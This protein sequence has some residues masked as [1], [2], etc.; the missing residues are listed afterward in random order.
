MGW[1]L[2]LGIATVAGCSGMGATPAPPVGNAE[3]SN[4]FIDDVPVSEEAFDAMMSTLSGDREGWYCAELEWVDEDGNLQGG[5]REGWLATDP[6][7]HLYRVVLRTAGPDSRSE[8]TRVRRH[9][10]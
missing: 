3:P 8:V 9:R 10:R 7:G 2:A 6:K 5:G 4:F 1:L